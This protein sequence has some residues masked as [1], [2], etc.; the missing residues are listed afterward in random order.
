MVWGAFYSQTRSNLVPME[1]DMD[2]PAAGYTAT[3]YLDIFEEYL[4][5]IWEPG[6]IYIQDNASVYTAR[7]VRNWLAETGIKTIEWPPYSPD[8]NPIE[9][10]W[11]RLKEL[12]Y[13]VRP[14]IEQVK[15][16]DD[17]IRKALFEALEL[18]WEHIDDELLTTLADSMPHRVQAVISA[19]GWYTKF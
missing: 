19:K 2:S 6:L 1:R 14:D 18:A 4:P 10:L 3:S 5:T 17:N 7:K 13:E 15:G 9:H 11:K 12:V 16:S 8:L